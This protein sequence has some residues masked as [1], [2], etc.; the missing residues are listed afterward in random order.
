MKK[1]FSAALGLILLLASLPG[2]SQV[3][4][5]LDSYF[6]NEH[7]NDP[8]GKLIST[9]YKWEETDNGGFSIFGDAFKK[10][11]AQLNT[12]YDEPTAEN[13]KR[14]DIYII[15]DPDTKKE[16]PKPKYIEPRDVK[17][18]AEWVKQ[19]GV[20]LMMANDSANVELKHFNTLAAKFGIHFN[21]DLINH[22]TDDKHFLNGTFLII[23][24]PILKTARKIYM[25]DICSLALTGPAETM[26]RD[27]D[28]DIIGVA[29]YGKGAVMAVGDPWLYNE[30]TNGRLPKDYDNDK[31]AS[32]VAQWLVK[33]I[34]KK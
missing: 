32:D 14:A 3:R 33:Q 34:P 25:K 8:S 31:A 26:L 30:Y 24:N 2:Y 13:L 15:V 17:V 6:N 9:H 18:I 11:G 16:S 10:A 29:Q 22:V 5:L 21:D 23:D 28:A 4:V 12:L 7:I 27:G 19:G 1:I 20:L